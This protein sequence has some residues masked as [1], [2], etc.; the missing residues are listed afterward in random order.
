MME[1]WKT[2]KNKTYRDLVAKVPDDWCKMVFDLTFEK[3]KSKTSGYDYYVGTAIGEPV[4][5]SQYEDLR[6]WCKSEQGQAS[7]ADC[8]TDHNTRI[9]EVERAIGRV[10]ASE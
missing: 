8:L 1:T 7:L 10:V 5:L 4:T 9:S 2:H 6:K 3:R